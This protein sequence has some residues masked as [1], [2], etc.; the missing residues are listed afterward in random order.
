[1]IGFQEQ[2]HKA[3]RE[4]PVIGCEDL[5]FRSGFLRISICTEEKYEESFQLLEKDCSDGQ[6]PVI[7]M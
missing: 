4:R 5:K 6:S 7:E 3:G 1:M 2:E